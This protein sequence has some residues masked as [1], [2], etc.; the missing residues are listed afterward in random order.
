MFSHFFKKGAMIVSFEF[1]N[2]K[3]T[4]KGRISPQALI[5]GFGKGPISLNGYIPSITKSFQNTIKGGKFLPTLLLLFWPSFLS[6][7]TFLFSRVLFVHFFIIQVRCCQCSSFFMSFFRE[8]FA[9]SSGG[10]M[11]SSKVCL[12][13]VSSNYDLVHLH[14]D[15]DITSYQVSNIHTGDVVASDVVVFPDAGVVALVL[16]FQ[17]FRCFLFRCW[18]G[19]QLSNRASQKSWYAYGGNAWFGLTCFFSFYFV[20]A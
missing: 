19:R 14:D 3:R 2:I 9:Y 13:G 11:L 18:Q 17:R 20:K 10:R 12:I 6:P 5:C 8:H 15:Y 16:L 7:V 4:T 1:W